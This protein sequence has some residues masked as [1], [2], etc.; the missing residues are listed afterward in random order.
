MIITKIVEK[1]T[2]ISKRKKPEKLPSG[3]HEFPYSILLFERTQKRVDFY[4][5]MMAGQ[6]EEEEFENWEH[7]GFCLRNPLGQNVIR[8]K[9]D[10]A[11]ISF[12]RDAENVGYI[13]RMTG[14]SQYPDNNGM[15]GTPI[16]EKSVPSSFVRNS[17]SHTKLYEK[18]KINWYDNEVKKAKR[19]GQSIDYPK[20]TTSELKLP[21]DLM[22]LIMTE[23]EEEYDETPEAE[24]S[25]EG[26]IGFGGIQ[27]QIDYSM[28]KIIEDDDIL[29]PWRMDMNEE[30]L[31]DVRTLPPGEYPI[32]ASEGEKLG[33]YII[34]P[35]HTIERVYSVSE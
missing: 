8:K 22:N 28:I 4:R 20:K 31:M 34:R 27:G 15:T 18:F 21:E 1:I 5:K 3:S 6:E 2:S 35:D 7:F 13:G 24:F 19:A 17:I 10:L 14:I 23:T 33:T 9:I 26:Y 16:L 29:V 12:E 25:S 30:L 32:E 11:F